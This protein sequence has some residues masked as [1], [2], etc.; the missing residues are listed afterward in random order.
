MTTSIVD[1]RLR[2]E[3]GVRQEERPQVVAALSKLDRRLSRFDPAAVELVL[4]VKER[5]TPTQSTV[6]ECSVAGWPRL[7]A[8]ST[9]T[10][11][12]RALAEVRDELSRQLNDVVDKRVSRR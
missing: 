9:A 3:G 12:E 10:E 11:L 5:R 2:L 6:L 4:K 8:T 7:V 1:E